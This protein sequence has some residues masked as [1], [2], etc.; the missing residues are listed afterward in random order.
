MNNQQQERRGFGFVVGLVAGAFAGA[1]LALWL[2]P[3]AAEEIRGRV[4]GS[5]K[6][7]GLKASD[8]YDQAGARVGEVV[9]QLSRKTDTVRDQVV[10]A[11]ARG[12]HEVERVATA[13]KSGRG[14]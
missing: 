4:A 7:I 5:A 3:R 12:A 13:A 11:V 9:E 10:G 6:K 8:T 1:G 14:V 2:A